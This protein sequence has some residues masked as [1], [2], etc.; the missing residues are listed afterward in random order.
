MTPKQDAEA[1]RRR[2]CIFTGTRADYGLLKPLIA[3]LAADP[4]FELQLLA[5]GGHLAP[6]QGRTAHEIEA[7]GFAITEGVEILAD[8]SSATGIATAMGLGVMRFAEAL[9]RLAPD[10]LVILGDRY[11][12]FAAAGAA[13]VCRVPI[14]HL[15]GGE[16]TFGALDEAFRHA[17]TKMSH[18]HFTSTGGYRDRVV[19][20]GEHPS[21]VFNVGALGVANAATVQR[22][23]R[24]EVLHRLGL[25]PNTRFLLATFHPATNENA[26]PEAQLE[27][28]LRALDAFPDLSVVFTGAN[29]DEGGRALNDRLAA[30]ASHR[31]VRFR[32]VQ[33]LGLFLYLNAAREAEAVVGNS[34]SGII[35]VPSFGVPSVD[36]GRRQDGRVRSRSVLHAPV[37]A[38]AIAAAIRQ[39]LSPEFRTVAAAAPNPYEHADTLGAIMG[40]LRTVDPSHL[41]RKTFH[42]IGSADARAGDV[43]PGDG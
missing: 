15:H 8:S 34:S 32:F 26:A 5:T 25:M 37:D 1:G 29:A 27:E 11:E 6:S 19:Q 30:Q 3:A 20:L 23:E 16:A 28:M 33:S 36:I 18:L 39:A 2:I 41:T 10:L 43:E 35:E 40:A 22:L 31:P 14:A 9:T 7:D 12:A 13:T 24:A 21:R 17:I 42:D 38:A 4:A